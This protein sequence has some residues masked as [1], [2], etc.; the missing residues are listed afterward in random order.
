VIVQ[1]QE[2]S[3]DAQ[4]EVLEALAGDEPCIVLAVLGGIFAEGVDYPGDMLSQVVVVSPGL[5]QFNTEREL[6]KQY[7]QEA[8]G[9]GFSYAYLIP[10]LTRVVQAAGRLIR[11][12][13]DRG[14]IILIGK[15]FQDSRH[16][17]YLPTEWT[18]G[19]PES[20]LLEDPEFT[21]HRFFDE[22]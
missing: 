8:Y 13:D 9:H 11:S 2:S 22:G 10:G 19:D 17:R 20:L 3:A 16:F 6:L 21:V 1:R 7:Y 12:E 15:R 14:V 5:P 4:R 18:G